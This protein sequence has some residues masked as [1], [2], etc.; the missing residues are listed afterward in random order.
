M[1]CNNSICGLDGECFLLS[2]VG[3]DTNRCAGIEIGSGAFRL[4]KQAKKSPSMKW[5]CAICHV[6]ATRA[7]NLLEHFLGQKHFPCC[8]EDKSK[9]REITQRYA[10]FREFM[11][12]VD[13]HVLPSKL[14]RQIGLGE[15]PER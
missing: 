4:K 13:V 11:P 9:S 15:P 12:T 2:V 8:S 6:E 3:R 7:G 10:V 5:I 1:S 14:H